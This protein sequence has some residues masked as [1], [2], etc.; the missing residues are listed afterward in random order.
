MNP[1]PF[2]GD[3]V[4]TDRVSNA[5]VEYNLIHDNLMAGCTG[6]HIDALDLNMDN[7]VIRGNRIWSCGTQCVFT[8]DPGSM[9]IENNMIEETNS[10]GDCG[11]PAELALMGTNVVRYNTIEG[12]DGYGLPD[13]PGNSTVYANIFLGATYCQT[14]VANVSVTYSFNIWLS[15]SGCG[16]NPKVCVPR[17]ANGSLWTN[18]DR[19]ADFHLASNDTCAVG[20]GNPNQYPA[21][22][23]DE[24]TRPQGGGTPD[25][26]ADER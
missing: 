22:D 3:L 1:T 8:G 9:L 11:G 5:V 7:G 10:C 20:A 25:A 4:L 13:R 15:G 23:L 2:C 14:N 16:S 26:G 18:T 24:A 6:A 21:Q 19:Q 12:G 17:L